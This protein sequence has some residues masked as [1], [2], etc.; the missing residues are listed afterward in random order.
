MLLLPSMQRA[1]GF[2]MAQN[3]PLIAYAA[4]TTWMMCNR[5]PDGLNGCIGS[6]LLHSF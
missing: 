1:L 2:T 6:M 4:L 3:S 5:R